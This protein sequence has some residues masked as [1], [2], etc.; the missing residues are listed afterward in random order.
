[1]ILSFGR[2]F[3]SKHLKLVS[4]LRTIL[5]IAVLVFTYTRLLCLINRESFNKKFPTEEN[6]KQKLTTLLAV[7][8]F[9]IIFN[10]PGIIL[11]IWE[12]V[13]FSRLEACR[14]FQENI[15]Y[16]TLNYMVTDLGDITIVFWALKRPN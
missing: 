14:S 4:L 16:S 1:M 10:L 15:G 8:S 5:P 6:Q 13:V 12:L 7:V 2:E 9:F 11:I 3:S